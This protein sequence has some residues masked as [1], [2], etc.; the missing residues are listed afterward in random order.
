[1]DTNILAICGE[2]DKVFDFEKIKSD[3]NFVFEADPN[4]TPITLF[5]ESGS[6]VTVNSWIE[7]ANYV[8]GGWTNNVSDF[9]NGEQI[10][11]FL[12]C[13]AIVLVTFFERKYSFLQ[14]I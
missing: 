11:F 1:M 3:P 12:F 7:C 6:A 10:L 8:N 4:F 5:N 14:R 9:I 13:S 2:S